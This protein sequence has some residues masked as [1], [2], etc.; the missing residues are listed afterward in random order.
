MKNARFLKR[1]VSGM[2]AGECF[3]KGVDAILL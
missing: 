2:R 1:S 3:T